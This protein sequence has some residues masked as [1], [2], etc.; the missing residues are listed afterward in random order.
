MKHKSR[1]KSYRSTLDAYYKQ[2]KYWKYAVSNGQSNKYKTFLMYYIY[3][4]GELQ[5][6]IKRIKINLNK[7]NDIKK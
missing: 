6:E 5:Y 2:L 7:R 1:I 3:M 4:I